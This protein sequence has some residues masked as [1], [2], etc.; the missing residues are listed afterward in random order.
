MKGTLTQSQI[1]II[2]LALI[3]LVF[4]FLLIN[5]FISPGS[6]E[7][8]LNLP[9]GVWISFSSADSK[10]FVPPPVVWFGETL[11]LNS[12]SVSFEQVFTKGTGKEIIFP[13]KSVYV[14]NTIGL[15]DDLDYGAPDIMA[16]ILFSGTLPAELAEKLSTGNLIE[17]DY[18]TQNPASPMIAMYPLVTDRFN[19][20]SSNE[21]RICD[22]EEFCYLDKYASF[23]EIK[24]TVS[25]DAEKLRKH[26]LSKGFT[27]KK[28]SFIDDI[29]LTLKYSTNLD[30]QPKN[31]LSLIEIE[32]ETL[33]LRDLI[34][35]GIC[36]CNGGD[37][38]CNFEFL[39]VEKC[40]PKYVSITP[41]M[42]SRVSKGEAVRWVRET[43]DPT[44][45]QI[46]YYADLVSNRTYLFESFQELQSPE[47]EIFAKEREDTPVKDLLIYPCRS[48]V[49]LEEQPLLYNRV[50]SVD[51]KTINW[52]DCNS[53]SF[54]RLTYSGSEELSTW[55]CRKSDADEYFIYNLYAYC[56][57]EEES[58][59]SLPDPVYLSG[60]IPFGGFKKKIDFPVIRL[61]DLSYGQYKECAFMWTVYV[62]EKFAEAMEKGESITI[63]PQVKIEPIE[64]NFKFS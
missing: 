36:S 58:L 43:I 24:Y 22:R 23:G 39:A 61:L 51:G 35:E 41:V 5:A 8:Y 28:E 38:E 7:G 3:F 44:Y 30:T 48:V 63:P 14:S 34:S 40:C 37:C 11:T 19:N 12:A 33:T 60:I 57:L 52:D 45:F 6:E 26:Y 16:Y 10:M 47:K 15:P 55:F 20:P 17:F 62:I 54:L 59:P 50:K 18:Q 9:D 1:L 31:Y 25:I 4:T 64:V 56:K 46:V 42:I 32:N 2:L 21:I 13:A 49:R 27:F 53:E 29:N